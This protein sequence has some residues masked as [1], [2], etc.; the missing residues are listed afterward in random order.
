[1]K[2]IDQ[3]EYDDGNGDGVLG[4]VAFITDWAQ[5]PYGML[6]IGRTSLY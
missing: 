5:A 2:R 1:M 4:G 6:W 3:I